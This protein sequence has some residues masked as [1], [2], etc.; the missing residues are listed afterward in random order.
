MGMHMD[1]SLCS[2]RENSNYSKVQ[3][4][5]QKLAGGVSTEGNP[6]ITDWA[7]RESK[8]LDPK[9]SIPCCRIPAPPGVHRGSDTAVVTIPG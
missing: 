7:Q 1:F 5:P 8:V 4:S 6:H 9:D 2:P 3:L